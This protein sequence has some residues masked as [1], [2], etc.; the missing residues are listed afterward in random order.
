MYH[1][2]IDICSYTYAHTYTCIHTHIHIHIHTQTHNLRR[3]RPYMNITTTTLLTH[4]LI[5]SRLKYCNSLLAPVN[6]DKIKHFDRT[7]N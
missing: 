5:M 7:I 4:S 2:L 3:L 1:A 6:K